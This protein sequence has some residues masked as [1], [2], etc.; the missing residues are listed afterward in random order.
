M[1]PPGRLRRRD[2]AGTFQHKVAGQPPAIEWA[3]RPSPHGAR[4]RYYLV[5]S[6]DKPQC[7]EHQECESSLAKLK[8]LH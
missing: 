6:E 3:M 7:S 5:I 8:D 4:K 2:R 1:E